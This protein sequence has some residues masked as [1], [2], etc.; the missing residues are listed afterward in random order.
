LKWPQ[1]GTK[2]T[3]QEQP[4]K[5]RLSDLSAVPDFCAF[6]A[7]CGHFPEFQNTLLAVRWCRVIFPLTGALLSSF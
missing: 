1:K 7:F 6:C 2:I 3:K 5:T 4:L